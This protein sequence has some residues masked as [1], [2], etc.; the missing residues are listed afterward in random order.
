MIKSAFINIA[1]LSI[2]A[3][4]SVVLNKV[5]SMPWSLLII[6]LLLVGGVGYGLKLSRA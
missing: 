5:P 4:V 6:F 2:V 3:G 1:P